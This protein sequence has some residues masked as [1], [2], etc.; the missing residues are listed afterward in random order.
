M[1]TRVSTANNWK[2]LKITNITS[3]T[4]T[5]THTHRQCIRHDIVCAYNL[6]KRGK[7]VNAQCN[8]PPTSR[9]FPHDL[10]PAIMAHGVLTKN[11]DCR[12]RG[13]I[14]T[15]DGVA[16]RGWDG[17]WWRRGNVISEMASSAVLRERTFPRAFKDALHFSVAFCIPPR[18]IVRFFFRA[19]AQPSSPSRPRRKTIARNF[20]HKRLINW[21]PRRAGEVIQRFIE[22]LLET[23]SS[24]IA[25]NWAELLRHFCWVTERKILQ[26]KRVI[27]KVA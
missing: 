7:N 27:M 3:R 15:A 11:N 22:P 10:W 25:N 5:H 16:R 20:H 4:H 1:L 23:L 18:T 12:Y 14:M 9:N 8:F 2:Y 21:K 17:G 24:D 6:I 19:A 26:I 13:R